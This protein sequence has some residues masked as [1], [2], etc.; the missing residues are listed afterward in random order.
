MSTVSPSD[1]SHAP[2]VSLAIAGMSC[3]HCVAA[4]R[5]AL[6]QV[7]GVRDGQVAIGSARFAVDPAAGA[8]DAVARAA[9]DAINDAGYDAHVADAASDEPAPSPRG[10]P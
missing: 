5:S 4:V 10:L 6:D 9:I 2:T 7:P 3:G 8:T 1:Q